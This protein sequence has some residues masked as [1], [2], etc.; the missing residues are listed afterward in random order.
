MSF[1]VVSFLFY[2][3]SSQVGRE[4]SLE[5]SGR[6]IDE[7]L[8]SSPKDSCVKNVRHNRENFKAE[9]KR[10]R[11]AACLVNGCVWLEPIS[12]NKTERIQFNFILL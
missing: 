4:K 10:R 1:E 11:E 12:L 9:G 7:K 8:L 2:Y 6:N 5:L 3:C